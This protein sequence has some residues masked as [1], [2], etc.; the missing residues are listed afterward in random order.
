MREVMSVRHA[1]LALLSEGPR[2]SRQ[3]REEFEAWTGDEWSLNVGQVDMALQRLEREGL[4]E[5]DAAGADGPQSGFRITA[6][7]ERELAGWLRTPPDL[8]FP[9]HDELATKILVALRVPG[10]DVHEVAQAHRRYLVEL[11]VQWTR[12]KQDNADHD[13][14]LA[15]AVDA[16][17]LRLD[18]VIRWLDAADDRLERAA[19]S[20][21]RPVPPALPGLRVRV[22][23]PPSRTN[24][25]WP[26]GAIDDRIRTSDADRERATARLRDHYAEGRLTREE[27][28]ERVMAALKART[29]G[30]LRRVM[31]DLPEPSPARQQARTPPPAAVPRPVLGR[32]GARILPL[33][34]LALL[35]VL[36]IPD[37]EWPFPAFFEVVLVFALIVCA[38][39]IIAAARFRQRI[40]RR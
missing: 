12:V 11:M 9:P 31:S 22:G 35:G 40:R 32:R 37:G 18:S 23:V 10:T 39:T 4:A 13:L 7:G 21:P 15:L 38:A 28:D 6:D 29:A 20:P 16:E 34:A 19:A 14:G 30:D 1:L 17:L 8:A 33:A 2:Y 36:L 25:Q 26:S 24:H 5:S 27:L 3:L